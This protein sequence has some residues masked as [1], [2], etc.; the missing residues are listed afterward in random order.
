MASAFCKLQKFDIK[1]RSTHI[2]LFLDPTEGQ[3]IKQCTFDQIEDIHS[4]PLD[5]GTIKLEHR[6]FVVDG[7]VDSMESDAIKFWLDISE[8]AVALSM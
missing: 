5:K 6:E 4:I 2:L 8:S 7:D 1:S 3:G